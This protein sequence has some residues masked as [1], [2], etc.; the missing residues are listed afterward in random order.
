MS[1]VV[2]FSDAAQLYAEYA[3]VVE[4]M[5]REFVQSISSFLDSIVAELRPMVLP[6]ILHEKQTGASYRYWWLA[7]QATD[8]ESHPLLWFEA[9][10]PAIV[11]SCRLTVTACAPSATAQELASYI[12][13]SKEPPLAPY[14]KSAAGRR[15]SLFF[16]TVSYA[17]GDPIEHVAEPI[18]CLLL[19]LRETERSLA[20]T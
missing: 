9:S 5:R 13:V 18:S 11:S 4:L 16:F 2:R 10:Q 12:T 14:C 3:A 20:A 8:M 17:D 6:E 7:N 19:A 1:E 15:W